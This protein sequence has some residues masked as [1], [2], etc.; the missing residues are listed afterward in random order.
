MWIE[1]LLGRIN[2]RLAIG[3]AVGVAVGVAV[4]AAVE[5]GKAAHVPLAG[6]IYACDGD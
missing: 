5:L 6:C 1:F 2:I 4:G 3:A